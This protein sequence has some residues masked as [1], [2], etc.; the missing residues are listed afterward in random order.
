MKLNNKNLYL[1]GLIAV[2]IVVYW[3]WFFN[4]LVLIIYPISLLLMYIFIF[5]SVEA[6]NLASYSRYMSTIVVFISIINLILLNSDKFVLKYKNIIYL[7][8]IGLFF[9]NTATRKLIIRKSK[10]IKVTNEIRNELIKTPEIIKNKNN[11]IYF[12]SGD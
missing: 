2:S 10:D 4:L 12:I 8:F 11:K 6:E 5:N 3:R 7:L 9:I 1:I